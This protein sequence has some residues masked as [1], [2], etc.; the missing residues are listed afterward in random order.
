M[1][2]LKLCLTMTTTLCETASFFSA[3]G[4][5]LCLLGLWPFS[6]QPIAGQK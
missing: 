6:G 4:Q 1:Q 2:L 3:M 5:N